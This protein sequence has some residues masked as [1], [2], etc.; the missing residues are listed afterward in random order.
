MQVLWKCPL[1]DERYVSERGWEKAT[2]D[3]CPFHPEG[4]VAAYRQ[5]SDWR[6]PAP[7]MIVDLLRTWPVDGAE[8]FLIGDKE[9]DLAAA[10]GAGIAGHRFIGGDLGTFTAGLLRSVA[11]RPANSGSSLSGSASLGPGL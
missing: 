4:V 8:S 7:G 11:N 3:R 6:K 5:V 9:S 1:S 2:L 10:A